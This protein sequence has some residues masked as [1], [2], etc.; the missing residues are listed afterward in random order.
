MNLATFPE[1][2]VI[3]VCVCVAYWG[4]YIVRELAAQRGVI[5]KKHFLGPF[6]MSL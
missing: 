4:G 6:S 1:S 3:G 2:S 5:T